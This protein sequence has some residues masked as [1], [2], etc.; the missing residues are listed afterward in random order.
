M[1]Q[2]AAALIVAHNHPSGDRKPSLTVIRITSKLAAAPKLVDVRLL[3]HFIVSGGD[4]YSFTD[5]GLL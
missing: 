2:M 3:D 4:A 1:E 5:G